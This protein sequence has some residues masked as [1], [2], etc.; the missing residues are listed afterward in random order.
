MRSILKRKKGQGHIEM[1]M[2]FT[3]FL[4]F[5]ITML[6]FFR[7]AVKSRGVTLTLVEGNIIENLSTQVYFFSVKA[8]NPNCFCFSNPYEAEGNVIIFDSSANVLGGW[9][10][11]DRICIERSSSNFF[12]VYMSDEFKSSSGTC[13]NVI[14]VDAENDVGLLRTITAVSNSSLWNFKQ[15]YDQNYTKLQERMGMSY[16]FRFI[17]FNSEHEQVMELQRKIPLGKPVYSRDKPVEIVYE[18]GEVEESI[19]RFYAW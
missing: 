11:G 10:S 19:I 3:L 16:D 5:I 8:S 2:S 4:G 17:V 14:T 15:E 13:N 1:I 18:N 6:V 12:Y 7:P 9:V